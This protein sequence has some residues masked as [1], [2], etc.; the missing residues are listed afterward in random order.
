M[1]LLRLFKSI[2]T[3]PFLIAVI[4]IFFVIF[5]WTMLYSAQVSYAPDNNQDS[6]ISRCLS[7]IY[8]DSFAS[9]IGCMDSILARS[10]AYWP[11]KVLKA[12]VIYMDMSDNEDY[13][14]Q[15]Y[16]QRLIDSSIIALQSHLDTVPQDAWGA[17]FLGTALGYRAVWEG[18]HGSL[19]KAISLGLRAGKSYGQMAQ[20]DSTLYDA[21]L[22]MGSLHYWRSA[23]LGILRS[24]PFIPD[25]RRRGIEELSRAREKSH[26]SR[27]TA[28]LGL[29][30]IYNDRK[31]Y[32]KALAIADSL[33]AAGITGRQVLWLKATVCFA[34]SDAE[35][36]IAAFETIKSG[37]L[38]K[39][40]QN[41]YNLITCGYYLGLANYIN[42][43]KEAA[44]KHFEEILNY[45]VSPQIAKRSAKRLES[46]RNYKQK[47]IDGKN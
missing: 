12:G 18:Q 16:C 22:G 14:R 21:Y 38:R 1:S 4:S 19:L 10:P 31:E 35:G 41:Y 5:N 3:Q 8:V 29:G 15:R 2:R 40:H 42:G 27:T 26:Y 36:T 23:K 39:G 33:L 25:Q 47:L 11:A 46:A 6:L 30:W 37:L 17:F 13:G 28:A 20:I 43:D 45:N 24:L 34:K 9:A 7:N 44:L 32:D